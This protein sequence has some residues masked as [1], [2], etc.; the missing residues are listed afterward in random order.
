VP[1]LAGVLAVGAAV[2]WPWLL[3]AEWWP[4]PW[5]AWL[6]R[7]YYDPCI[8]AT[9]PAQ[10]DA[11]YRTLVS[12]LGTRN[13][14]TLF[15]ENWNGSITATALAYSD[16]PEAATLLYAHATTGYPS[17]QWEMA[18]VGLIG[19]GRIVPEE[20][21]DI[22]RGLPRDGRSTVVA[23]ILMEKA[24]RYESVVHE[25]LD[26]D[27]PQ[28]PVRTWAARFVGRKEAKPMDKEQLIEMIERAFES[29]PKP[30]VPVNP[31]VLVDEC[32]ELRRLDA[33]LRAMPR[34]EL[35]LDDVE[36]VLDD[37]PHLTPKAYL[38]LLPTC[39]VTTLRHPRGEMRRD[40][41]WAVYML[42]YCFDL[43]ERYPVEAR[44]PITEEQRAAV[45]AYLDFVAESEDFFRNGDPDLIREHIEN[46]RA[47]WS[48][49]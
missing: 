5:R 46:A 19:A 23:F 25:F 36:E 34:E 32:P 21:T 38:Y 18:L 22:Y 17:Q 48:R 35:A 10:K 43:R 28:E 44:P 40:E 15:E 14:M 1:L 13:L 2:Q 7:K 29:V 6:S 3:P 49:P 11:A 47:A 24:H 30:D 31:D 33:I 16:A 41:E 39:L 27:S 12:K 37:Y 20:L 4:G 45:H 42:G 9:T 8:L 26:R